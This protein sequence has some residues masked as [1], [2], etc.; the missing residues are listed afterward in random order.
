MPGESEFDWLKAT[1]ADRSLLYAACKALVDRGHVSWND[2]FDRSLGRQPGTDYLENF[3]RGLN[4]RKDAHL[5]SEFLQKNFP[6]AAYELRRSLAPAQVRTVWSSFLDTIKDDRQRLVVVA[7]KAGTPPVYRDPPGFSTVY[8]SEPF[9]LQFD[10]PFGGAAVCLRADKGY[11]FFQP[12]PDRIVANVHSGVHWLTRD[13]DDISPAPLVVND[14]RL[15]DSFYVLTGDADLMA[16]ITE[17][18]DP[19]F[20]V[21]ERRLDAFP[22][23]IQRSGSAWS[24][25]RTFFYYM[26]PLRRTQV[27]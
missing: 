3:R 7:A 9:Y 12:L 14:E 15:A 10:A 8:Y 27:D 20:P 23:I 22:T 21:Q 16:A 2:M 6:Q 1:N 25:H 11:W 17:G 26:P 24:L 18:A 13:E 5:I 19:A 4:S